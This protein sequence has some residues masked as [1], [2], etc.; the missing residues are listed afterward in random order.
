[1]HRYLVLLLVALSAFLGGFFFPKSALPSSQ[2][3]PNPAI[4][5]AGYHYINP[6]LECENTSNIEHNTQ[7][8]SLKKSLIKQIDDI[9]SAGKITRIAL[10]FR[11]LNNGPWFGIN[12]NDQFTPASLLKTPMMIAYLKTAEE[13]SSLLSEHLLYDPTDNPPESPNP[14][15]SPL[16]VNTPYTIEELL[17][18]MIAYSDNNAF[19]LLTLHMP[20]EQ[21]EQVHLDLGLTVPSES[22]PDD[23]ISVQQY[24]GLFRVLFNAS[25]LNRPMSEKALSILAT[26]S[27][28]DGLVAGVDDNIE[29]AH[30][31]GFRHG[32]NGID[33]LHDCGIIYYPN[34]PYLLCIMTKGHEFPSLATAI[35]DLSYSVYQN[36]KTLY[37][38]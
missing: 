38:N 26:A 21:I 7:L 11:D 10:Y 27:Y 36:I 1:M 14:A 24:A 28:H 23:F 12:E 9:Y 37:P 30:K 25:Y 16:I 17:T 15:I 4:R 33:Q 34:H 5:Q 20:Y 3:F 8:T 19:N 29:I 32:N 31:Y 22:T 6:L 13:N 35:K 2:S 18:R